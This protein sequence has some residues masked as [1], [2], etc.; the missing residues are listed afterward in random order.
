MRAPRRR[1]AARGFGLLD[2]L[3][4]MA[5]LGFGLLALANMQTRLVAQTTD[6]HSRSVANQ[7]ANE[8][9][10]TAL[11]DAPG[12]LDCYRVPAAGTCGN[13]NARA[14]TDAWATRVAAALPGTVTVTSTRN[15]TRLAVVIGWTGKDEDVARSLRAETDVQ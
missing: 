7:L 2:G 14:N 8:L 9:L 3:I 15:G 10:A 11:V 6:A 1:T 13:T 4:G 5:L 12:N